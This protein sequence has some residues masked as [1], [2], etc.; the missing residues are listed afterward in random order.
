MFLLV[1]N[2]FLYEEMFYLK[3]RSFS[4]VSFY[5]VRKSAKET[6]WA[7]T[8]TRAVNSLQLPNMIIPPH[9]IPS[10]KNTFTQRWNGKPDQFYLEV[11]GTQFYLEVIG[12]ICNRPRFL[13]P[14][15]HHACIMWLHLF[16]RSFYYP[17]L[18]HLE[19]GC[20]CCLIITW[21]LDFDFFEGV[22]EKQFCHTGFQMCIISICHPF[23][24]SLT[25]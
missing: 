17:T 5:L 23:P 18:L 25:Q 22:Q 19:N 21:S 6:M 14:H 16:Y 7:S 13:H 8:W 12:T 9:E 20:R 10:E 1:L 24:H 11:I 3:F 15:F 2:L 4:F